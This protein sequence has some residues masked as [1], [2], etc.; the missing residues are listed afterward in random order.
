MLTRVALCYDTGMK[1]PGI[2]PSLLGIFRL[3][4]GLRLL[5]HWLTLCVWVIQPDARSQVFPFVGIAETVFL[6][7]YLTWKWL[8]KILGRFYLPL[9]IL[10]ATAGP[11]VEYSANVA[12]R[13]RSGTSTGG[14]QAVLLIVILFIPLL[15][16]SW[17]YNLRSVIAFCIGSGLLDLAISLPL[18]RMGGPKTSDVLGI[19]ILR[20]LLFLMV[21]FTVVRLM[22]AQRSQ[23]NAMS[24][25][26]T[27]LARYATTLEQLTI[28]RERNRLARDLHDTLA[29][30]LSGLAVQLEAMGAVWESDPDQA[31]TMLNHSLEMTRS[32][33][34]ET[35]RAL[36]ALRASPLEDMGLGLAISTLA[37]SVAARLNARL[38]LD[39]PRQILGLSPEVEQCVYRIA[40]E[41]LNN[42]ARHADAKTI[43]LRISQN[44]TGTQ[45]F[46]TDDGHGFDIGA[47]NTEGHFGLRG[48]Q[49]RADLVGATL[50]VRS[51]PGEGTQLELVVGALS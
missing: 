39:V 14:E 15:L 33:L 40:D 43:Y 24:E 21:G 50:N 38:D 16:V 22:S 34:V 32:G 44:Q 11:I 2:E 30:T 29:H 12:L 13:L 36:H 47:A 48:M 28:S 46:I 31:H 35:R 26:N 25:A 10:I 42:I 7:I 4:V 41:A 6:L 51:N 45:L 49:E 18:E 3:F 8:Q 19:V 27:R 17:Q 1:A 37:E 9:A 5:L 23:R 20:S